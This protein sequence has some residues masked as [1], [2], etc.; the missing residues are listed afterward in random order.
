VAI[1]PRPHLR[2]QR[3]R[4]PSLGNTEFAQAMWRAATDSCTSFASGLRQSPSALPPTPKSRIQ[5]A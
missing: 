1:S 4:H 3:H 5:P 2:S